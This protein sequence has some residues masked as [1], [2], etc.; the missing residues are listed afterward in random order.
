MN[1]VLNCTK[2]SVFYLSSV[3]V[4][5]SSTK[6]P[7]RKGLHPLSCTDIQYR[8]KS[9]FKQFVLVLV[10]GMNLIQ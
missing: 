7:R 6:C 4:E 8:D 5:S 2:L 1:H 3:F 10:I 9:Y